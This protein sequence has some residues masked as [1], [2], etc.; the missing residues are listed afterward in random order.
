[1]I[2]RLADW[3]EKFSVA[4][5]AVGVFQGSAFGIF[6]AVVSLAISLWITKRSGD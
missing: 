4:A 2:K 3:L 6:V 5:A 1:M